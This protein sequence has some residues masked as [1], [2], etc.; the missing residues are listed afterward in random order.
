MG[1]LLAAA[2]S[3]DGLPIAK[4]NPAWLDP[5]RPRSA[6]Q[7]ITLRFHYDGGDIDP[8]NPTAEPRGGDYGARRVWETL[9]N[10]NWTTVAAALSR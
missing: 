6:V 7:L 1:P 5:S 8:D 9:H 3:T 10:S 4:A 2:G